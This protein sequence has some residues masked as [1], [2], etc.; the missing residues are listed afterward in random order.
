MVEEAGSPSSKSASSSGGSSTSNTPRKVTTPPRKGAG[1]VFQD[2]YQN[3]TAWTGTGK[4]DIMDKTKKIPKTPYCSRPTDQKL[5]VTIYEQATKGLDIIYKGEDAQGTKFT[6][7]MFGKKLHKQALKTGLDAVFEFNIDGNNISILLEWQKIT[8]EQV[9]KAL[10][11]KL[12]NGEYDQYDIYNMEWSEEMI[13]KSISEDLQLA[14]EKSAKDTDGFG[15]L[16]WMAIVE[17]NVSVSDSALRAMELTLKEIKL[18]DYPGEHVP[19]CTTKI[20]QIC[21]HLDRADSLPNDINTTICNALIYCSNEEYRAYFTAK[22]TQANLK[23]LTDTWRELLKEA[24]VLYR[25]IHD[26]NQWILKAK[27]PSAKDNN[28]LV[29]GLVAAVRSEFIKLEPK[30]RQGGNKREVTC[31]GCGE[32]GHIKPNCPNKGAAN[33]KAG[34][35]G[36]VKQQSF[37]PKDAP[38]KGESESVTNGGGTFLHCRKCGFWRKSDHVKAHMTKDH[39]K[40]FPPKDKPAATIAAVH[41]DEAGSPTLCGLRL[42]I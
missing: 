16:L 18:T 38:A 15:P 20:E 24:D 1:G 34:G 8:Y 7:S 21:S 19:S 2:S 26:G 42:Q 9:E 3:E 6:L 35:G 25:A 4:T 36:G 37:K 28:E 33:Q 10:K 13:N 27:K 14:L 17:I 30:I 11:D 39:D 41:D 22:K 5:Q 12:S 32:K 29:A 31:Y 23:K 40:T